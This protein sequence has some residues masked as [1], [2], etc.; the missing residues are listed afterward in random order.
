M[1]IQWFPGHMTKAL[2]MMDKEIKVV[3]I[4]VYVVDSRAP[5]S[6]VNP[7]LNSLIGNKPVVYVLSKADL[8]EDKDIR[9][10]VRFFTSD[11]T[12][13]IALN[14]TSSSSGKQ[15]IGMIKKLLSNKIENNKRKNISLPL[16]AMVIGVPNCGK[17]T[18]INNICGKA[19]ALAGN[20]PGVTKGKQWV[21]IEN[22]FEFLDTP[23]T[24]W[25]SFEDEKVALNLA[26]IGSIK[27]DVIDINE[28]SYSLINTLREID[29]KILKDRYGIDF[30]DDEENIEV[31]DKICTARKC[32]LKGNE[33]D[34][35][36]CARI[37]ID[38]FRKGK[39][40]K[41]ILD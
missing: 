7:E 22:G 27:D 33:P 31:F 11:T 34:Y 19:R 41:I 13:A 40:G 23:G 20:K 25:P 28:L 3:D 8:V 39:M 17:S 32:L 29:P 4:I 30:G 14:S 2:R 37:I 15:I 36:R 16:R 6:C 26:Y 9:K 10:W 1:N 38:D 18:L 24:L 35:D 5:K 21:S 12:M